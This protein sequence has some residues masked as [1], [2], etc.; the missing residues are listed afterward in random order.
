MVIIRRSWDLHALGALL[1]E[2]G[3]VIKRGAK[4]FLFCFV[5]NSVRYY[6]KKQCRCNAKKDNFF[7]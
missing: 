3:F 7:I 4:N 2:W 6:D 5:L 1:Q